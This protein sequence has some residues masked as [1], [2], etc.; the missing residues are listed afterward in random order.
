MLWICYCVTGGCLVERVAILWVC[1]CVT[2][3]CLVD[4]SYVFGL[5][6]CTGGL[7]G[8]QGSYV[9]FFTLYRWVV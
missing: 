4:N 5:L 3:G 2:V 9:V 7:F 6:L 1:Y 8:G